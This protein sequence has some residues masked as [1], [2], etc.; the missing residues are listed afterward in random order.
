MKA[1]LGI[2]PGY[3]ASA[4]LLLFVLVGYPLLGQAA[5]EDEIAEGGRIFRDKCLVC[6]S[7]GKGLRLGP[8][9]RDIHKRRDMAWLMRFVTDP[10]GMSE[11]D[12]DAQKLVAEF[13]GRVMQPSDLNEKQHAEI[14]AFIEEQSNALAPVATAQPAVAAVPAQAATAQ[15]VAAAIPAQAATAQPAA[16]AVPAQAAQSHTALPLSDQEFERAKQIFFNRC[17]GCHG[18]LRT[19]AT[20]PDIEPKRAEELG[21]EAIQVLLV[22]GLPGGMPAFGKEGVLSP[23]EVDLMTRYLFKTPPEPPQR[24]LAM[25]QASW[26][27]HVPV[28]AR[29]KAPQTKR[30]WQNYFG[31]ILRDAGKV[32]ILDGST[33]EL[34]G[35]V[36]TGF[37]V[38]IL[39]SSS[40]G[41][42]FYAI[43]R[44]GK[45]T[46]IDL[47]PEKPQ[48]V[49]EVQGCYDARSV[50]A[51]KYKGYEDKLVIEG[52]Y[53]PPQYVVMDGLTLEPKTVVDITTPTY[54]TNQPLKE[55]RVASI[56]S[57]HD[58]PDWI[59][60][61]KESGH[62]AVVDYSKPGFPVASKI[63]AERFLHDG[64]WDHTGRYF[65]VAANT[66]EQMVVVDVKTQKLV[67]K[68]KTG[69]RPH[70]GRGAN[71]EDPEFGWVNATPHIGEPKLTIYGADPEKKPQYAWKVVREVKLPATGGLFVKTHPRSP[72]VWVDSPMSNEPTAT[73]QVCV[74]SKKSGQ[75]E[76]CWAVSDHDRVVHFD[77]NRAGSEVWVS[78][79]G[80]RGE[81]VVY[82]DKTLQE[83]ARI[84]G[85]WLVTPTGKFNVYNTAHDVY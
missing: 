15:T 20:G 70:P 23:E 19:G 62:V 25:I 71:W 47:W 22:S 80:K 4:L 48:L 8:D 54:D 73:R 41:R 75:I 83:K 40:T 72:W 33:K 66:R 65:M 17:A 6:H 74:Y 53:W 69:V 36:D 44:D 3:L 84:K 46:M 82:D 57:S 7:I 79:W 37:A 60:S 16:A 68:F 42:Y 38:H 26:K 78:V 51:S 5:T 49:A 58:G 56:V 85:D 2:R 21:E 63:P 13:K 43:G 81:L 12:P 35:I 39:R 30:D 76:K 59:V 29:P 64:G 34:V 1:R 14:F 10:K 77:Y 27:L 61:L 18:T 50:D 9:L 52:C 24:P 32:A 28:A 67:T 31:V 11:S 45:V 55:N